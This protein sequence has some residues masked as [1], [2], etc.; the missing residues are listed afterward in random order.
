MISKEFPDSRGRSRDGS[1]SNYYFVHF[2]YIHFVI[3]Y[4]ALIEN[5]LKLHDSVFFG[6]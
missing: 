6:S 1:V 3:R 4:N 2:H 5:C